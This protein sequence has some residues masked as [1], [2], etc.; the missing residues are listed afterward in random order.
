MEST[1]F[2]H[3]RA[4]AKKK[5]LKPSS[6]LPVRPYLSMCQRGSHWMEF[7]KVQYWERLYK[8]TAEKIQIV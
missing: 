4:L 2:R 3:V 8:K 6:C 5:F 1:I 7:N